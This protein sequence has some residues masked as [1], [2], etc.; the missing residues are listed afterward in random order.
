MNVYTGKLM[1]RNITAQ[2]K[3]EYCLV[4]LQAPDA[5]RKVNEGSVTLDG[6]QW[7]FIQ[8]FN[9]KTQCMLVWCIV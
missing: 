9:L 5:V 1:N 4:A 6:A 7:T 8:I 3:I 2:L